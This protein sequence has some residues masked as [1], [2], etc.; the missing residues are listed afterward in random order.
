METSLQEYEFNQALKM[1]E[2]ENISGEEKVEMLMEIAKGIQQKPKSPKELYNAIK[3]YD[4]ALEICPST[5]LLL[6]ARVEAKKGTA[7]QAIPENGLVNLNLAQAQYEKSIPVLEKLGVP[8]E[9][10]EAEMNLGLVLQSLFGM[11][12]VPITECIKAYQRSL[13]V[14]NSKKF[15]SEYAI[16]HNN[17]ATAFLSIPMSDERSKMR[18]AM[19]VQSFEA[20]LEVVNLID[21]PTEYAMLQNNL[22]NALQYASSSHP[23]ENNLRAN[24]AYDEA[25]KVRNERDTPL[26]YANTICNKANSLRN[27][28]DDFDKP[29]TGNRENLMTAQ[30][31][32][33]KASTIFK[34]NGDLAKVAVVDEVL[35]EI[36]QDLGTGKSG[37][38]DGQG[39]GNER[40]S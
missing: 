4:K 15:P 27:L 39:F 22:G 11:G 30:D 38:R 16:L 28:P 9:L 6:I 1:I 34:V 8:E 3:L 32:Y 26:E 40:V 31:L 35:L 33:R 7:Y 18:E 23:V 13:K 17:L 29:E 2:E 10:A 19:A 25:L 12:K 36:A 20:A 14:F 5:E 21:Y 37:S 24:E